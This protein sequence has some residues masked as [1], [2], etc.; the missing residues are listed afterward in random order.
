MMT[1]VYAW[2][3]ILCY[4]LA[5]REQA[6]GDKWQSAFAFGGSFVFAAL[7]IREAFF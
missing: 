1:I 4:D 2:L 7:T 5:K 3:S 6:D